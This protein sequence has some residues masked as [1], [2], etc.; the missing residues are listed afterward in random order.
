MSDASSDGKC[1]PMSEDVELAQVL[2]EMRHVADALRDDPLALTHPKIIQR[3][4]AALA[5]YEPLMKAAE[6]RCLLDDRDAYI[7]DVER[8]NGAIIREALALFAPKEGA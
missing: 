7:G 2:A 5:K 4:A 8:A 6:A 3:W 1:G